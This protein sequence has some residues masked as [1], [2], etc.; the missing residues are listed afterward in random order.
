[1]A[2]TEND[3]TPATYV[4]SRTDIDPSAL[5]LVPRSVLIIGYRLAGADSANDGQKIRLTSSSQAATLYGTGSALHLMARRAFQHGD[6]AS[7][8]GDSLPTIYGW[9]TAPPSGVSAK[10]TMTFAGTATADGQISFQVNEQT[11]LLT[12][13]SGESA[14]DLRTRFL[15][16][17]GTI[18]SVLAH[19][20]AANATA[21][22]VDFDAREAG[23]I[24]NDLRIRG[25]TT[26]S[27]GIT[28]AFPA[29]TV[30]AGVVD[31]VPELDAILGDKE[32]DAIVVPQDDAATLTAIV[33]HVDDS[34][35]SQEG[36]RQAVVLATRGTLG[37]A[38]GVTTALQKRHVA[39]GWLP[40]VSSTVAT[41]TRYE[42]A[43]EIGVR[44]Y[45]EATPNANRSQLPLVTGGSRVELDKTT[46]NDAIGLPG[47]GIGGLITLNAPRDPR[48]GSTAVK[49]VTTANIDQRPGGTTPNTL[50]QPFEHTR[51][52]Q[53]VTQGLEEVGDN[54]VKQPA[55]AQPTDENREALRSNVVSLLNGF[56]DAN[57]LRFNASAVTVEFK[58]VGGSLRW[59]IDAPW[60]SIGAVDIVDIT[61]TILVGG[62]L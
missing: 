15:T 20:V 24:F 16:L 57:V 32:P 41:G 14:S 17:Y 29:P 60:T 11:L 4:K 38:Q 23:E 49:Y 22:I 44:L 43:A 51:N 52:E 1:M 46:T 47:T 3:R 31:M 55:N 59:V 50:W 42:C 25:D 39:C 40:D 35:T 53:L 30:G 27:P 13:I 48:F 45:R 56:A 2:T 6:I 61:S 18:S 58:D 34:W 21:E 54:F 5:Q 37:S 9:G 19:T 10:Q 33:S 7:S 36:S 62:Q 12:I 28:L 8:R 26:L